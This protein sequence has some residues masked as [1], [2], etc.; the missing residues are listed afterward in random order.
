MRDTYIRTG[1]GFLVAYAMTSR[2]SFD[3]AR[4]H[5]SQILRVKDSD[6]FPMVLVANKADLEDQRMFHELTRLFIFMQIHGCCL[7]S[8]FTELLLILR[9]LSVFCQPVAF[10]FRCDFFSHPYLGEIPEVEGRSL[11]NQWG[12]PFFETS[13][14]NRQ[15]VDE[16]F[17]EAVREVRRADQASMSQSNKPQKKMTSKKPGGGCILF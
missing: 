15:N 5:H 6:K 10:H 1:E 8:L 9:R 13:A 16:C 3:D 2:T 17:F 4:Q 7:G 14:F 11:A 12:V